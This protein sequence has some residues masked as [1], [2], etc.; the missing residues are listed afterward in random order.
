M[1]PLLRARLFAAQGKPAEVAQAY[2]RS[3]RANAA[4][5]SST[6]ASCS[7]KTKLKLSEADE[8]L[9][10]ANLVLDVEK[11]RPDA[12]LLAGPR[13]GRDRVDVQRET[14]QQTASRH[15]PARG[16][17]QGQPSLRGGL[18]HAG[19]D[20]PEAQRTRAAAIAVLKED[21]KA[22]PRDATAA[23]RLV[24][25]LAERQAG[26]QP[27][28]AADLAEAKRIAAEVCRPRQQGPR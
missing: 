9:R 5:A 8:A 19:R 2:S 23:S 28:A 7:G 16:G 13:P 14:A 15:R 18:S 12:V 1:G 11:N 10:Q 24:E 17:H 6:C 20:P 4:R 27:P 26:G 21:L 3:A 22:N 25:L